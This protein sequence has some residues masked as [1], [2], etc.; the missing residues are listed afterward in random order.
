MSGDMLSDDEA[1]NVVST[2]ASAA[3]V[4]ARWSM[5]LSGRSLNE[6]SLS[7]PPPRVEDTMQT[8]STKSERDQALP[9]S[10]SPTGAEAPR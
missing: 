5:A 9:D 8:A 4:R 10:G 7:R 1:Q 6:D 3:V 2:E